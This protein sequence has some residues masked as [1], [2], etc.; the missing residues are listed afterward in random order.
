MICTAVKLNIHKQGRERE[1]ERERFCTH[2][3]NMSACDARE[4]LVA[5]PII[6]PHFSLI[7]LFE[8]PCSTLSLN[9]TPPPS[10]RPR[11]IT[12]NTIFIFTFNFLSYFLVSKRKTRDFF[13]FYSQIDKKTR[14]KRK[15][16]QRLELSIM[17]KN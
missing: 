3:K 17:I 5:L 16:K 14:T 2:E 4:F 6:T 15:K 13:L 9:S 12:L 7:F 10:S 8:F 11:F 1:R